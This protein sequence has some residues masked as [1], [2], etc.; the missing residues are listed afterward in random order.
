M[1]LGNATKTSASVSGI[2]LA[3]FLTAADYYGGAIGMLLRLTGALWLP[4]SLIAFVHGKQSI[5]YEMEARLGKREY[6]DVAKDI[7]P[8]ALLWFVSILFTAWLLTP[9]PR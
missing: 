2:A 4:V 6:I 1:R 7:T 3:V 8:R 9:T 5:V